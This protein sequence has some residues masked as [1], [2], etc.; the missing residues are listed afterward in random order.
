[1]LSPNIQR[2]SMFPP[3]CI[4]PAC[5]NIATKIETSDAEM[6]YSP[7]HNLCGTKPYV[8]RKRS[9]SAGGSDSSKRKPQTF[10]AIRSQL[11]H[12]VVRVTTVSRRGIRPAP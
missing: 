1:M 3:K 8:P 5:R 7:L 11:I 12:G 6:P 2:K 9:S 10:A 4:Q